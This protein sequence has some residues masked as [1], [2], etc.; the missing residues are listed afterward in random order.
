M[1]LNSYGTN[2]ILDA[3]TPKLEFWPKETWKV[4]SFNQIF[5]MYLE[6]ISLYKL[7]TIYLFLYNLY[8][9][10]KWSELSNSKNGPIEKIAEIRP[11]NLIIKLSFALTVLYGGKSRSKKF[12]NKWFCAKRKNFELKIIISMHLSVWLLMHGQRECMI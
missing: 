8:S 5:R 2:R 10:V 6:K 11:K 3:N 12:S 9:D 4:F 1:I 7:K